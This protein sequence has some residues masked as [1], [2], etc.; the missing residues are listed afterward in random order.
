MNTFENRMILKAADAIYLILD[1]EGICTGFFSPDSVL[2]SIQH[3]TA[4]DRNFTEILPQAA[5]PYVEKA[6]AEPDSEQSL[7]VFEFALDAQ[8]WVCLHVV[9]LDNKG[10]YLIAL[11]DITAE[12]TTLELMRSNERELESIASSI[13]HDMK[14]YMFKIKG[15]LS[16]LVEE[17]DRRYIER[18]QAIVEEMETVLD[19]L[20]N[21]IL[22]SGEET[23]MTKIDLGQLV[24]EIA[25]ANIPPDIEFVQDELPTICGHRI[26]VLQIFRNLIENAVV[27]GKPSKIEISTEETD[28]G[29]NLRITNDGQPFPNE[30][31]E[32]MLSKHNET[33]GKAPTR[34]LVIV[35]RLVQKHGWD[36]HLVSKDPTTFEI[37]I[38]VRKLSTQRRYK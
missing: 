28:N 14:N 1:K 16:L 23:E 17:N 26:S 34:G 37:V 8:T 35:Q 38:P 3:E 33:K 30:V 21:I 24:S 22:I 6:I 29:T 36:I 10:C 12:K 20:S 18:I 19:Y 31:Q 4:I 11:R 5:E 13:R 32:K 2:E 15:Y 9:Y 7:R 27:H 25:R